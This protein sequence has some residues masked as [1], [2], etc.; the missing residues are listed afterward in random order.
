MA[1]INL[2]K[3]MYRLFVSIV[4][5]LIV[6]HQVRAQEVHFSA[7]RQI[8]TFFNPAYTGFIE[9]DVRAGLI[10]RNQSPTHSKSYNTLGYDVDFSLLKHR[11]DNN[12]VI[13][14]GLNGYF[15]RAGTLGF[16]DNTFQA[17]FSF[18]QALDRKQRFYISIGL[19]AG[20][21]MRKIDASRATLEEGFDGI[22]GFTP[23]PTDIPYSNLKNKT[24]RLG[25]GALLFFNL[26]DAIKFHFG[27]G[28]YELAKQN[29]S[30][31]DGGSFRQH[32]RYV[33]NVGMEFNIKQFS[34][35][36]YF[37]AQ[38][39]QSENE[40]L[41]GSMFMYNSD[42]GQFN[43]ND[44]TYMIG[45]GIGYRHLDAVVLSAVASYRKF[46][47]GMAYDINISK[48]IR[49]TNSVGAVE[50]SLIYKD[51]FISSKSRKS[52]PLGCPKLYF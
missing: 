34:I 12:T 51:N 9:E 48:Q 19:Q 43:F 20:A 4:F 52:K 42:N 44:N 21:S 47:L 16:M 13:G 6:A 23:T 3:E 33:T 46:T 29:L 30:F 37:M 39:R 27:G 2:S 38:I 24:M 1:K 5:V 15:D 18:I 32:I 8:P 40:L 22:G 25:T 45:A 41:F 49:S 31:I 17:N 26:S 50:V 36:P 35:Q 11:T 14:V 7:I 28:A 10:Y